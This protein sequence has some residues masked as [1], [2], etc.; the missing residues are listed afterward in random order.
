VVT[1]IKKLDRYLLR[2]FL[3]SLVVVTLALGLT[4]VIINMVEELRD[5]IDHQVPI[6]SILEYYLYFGGWIVKSFLPAFVMLAA[7]F[8]IS[9]LARRQEILAMKASG[10]SLYRIALPLFVATALICVGHFYYNEYVFPPANQK[11]LE[12]KQ[13]T[14]EKKSKVAMTKVRNIYRQIDPGHFYTIA[15][16]DTERLTGENLRV[17]KTENNQLVELITAQKVVYDKFLWTAINGYRRTFKDGIKDTFEEFDSLYIGA[18]KDSP[19]DLAKRL[20]KPEDM[21]IEELR[22]YIDLMKRTGGPYTRESVDLKLKYAYP[23]ASF[24]VLLISIPFAANPRKG[25]VAV[26]FAAG[27]GFALVYFVLFRSLQSAAYNG[28]V[29]EFV[30]VWGVNLLFLAVGIILMVRAR[31]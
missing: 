17:Y 10:R 23:L 3:S 29:P 7:L 21:G 27:A 16:F 8:S 2:Y 15:H 20:G 12:I 1:S 13:F 19:Q 22:E 24:I 4:I 31:K 30:G 28:K 11:R 18:I 9:I 25:G 14:I 26:S 5:F 6:L